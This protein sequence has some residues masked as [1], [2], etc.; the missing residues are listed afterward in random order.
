MDDRRL[1]SPSAHPEVRA[2]LK[3]QAARVGSTRE[4]ACLPGGASRFTADLLSAAIGRPDLMEEVTADEL[5][6]APTTT[7][8]AVITPKAR[9]ARLT[10]WLSPAAWQEIHDLALDPDAPVW[11]ALSALDNEPYPHGQTPRRM[12]I[13][14]DRILRAVI[15]HGVDAVLDGDSPADDVDDSLQGELPLAM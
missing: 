14:T 8:P 2:W 6:A 10:I 12:R 5:A 11:R 9:D 7:L 1:L 15:Q 13:L 4:R 3:A